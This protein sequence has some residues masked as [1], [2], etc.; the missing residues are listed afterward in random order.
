MQYPYRLFYAKDLHVCGPAKMSIENGAT[1]V[2]STIPPYLHMVF[3]KEFMMRHNK[4]VPLS[5][6]YYKGSLCTYHILMGMLIPRAFVTPLPHA[7]RPAPRCIE[8]EEELERAVLRKRAAKM[9]KAL[10]R[11]GV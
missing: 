6:V 4:D 11:A 8:D 5:Y 2:W 9:K 7:D 3:A 10:E 1:Y